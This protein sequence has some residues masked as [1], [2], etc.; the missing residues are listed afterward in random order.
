[1]LL[2][3]SAPDVCTI[4][5]EK[6]PWTM[7]MLTRTHRR[8]PAVFGL[9]VHGP[10]VSASFLFLWGSLSGPRPYLNS[11]PP[12]SLANNILARKRVGTRRFGASCTDLSL[13]A[14]GQGLRPMVGSTAAHWESRARY[15]CWTH[16]CTRFGYLS[17]IS[18]GSL[19]ILLQLPGSASA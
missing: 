5:H 9:C 4:T 10:T 17:P 16:H 6:K 18:E 14:D 2:Q 7:Y 19:P 13:V 12:I 1:M 8:R 15:P 11:T 3:Q